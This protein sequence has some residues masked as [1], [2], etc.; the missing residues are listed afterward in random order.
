MMLDFTWITNRVGLGGAIWDA[1]NMAELARLGITHIIDMQIEFD[2]TRLAQPFGIAVCWN[3]TDDDFKPKPAELFRRG[4]EFAERALDDPQAKLYVHCAAGIHRGPMMALA[5][6]GST[7]WELD[8]A[9]DAIETKRPVAE[10][11]EVYLNSVK[12]F[13][14]QASTF[15]S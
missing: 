9:L 8:A 3:P 7:G 15:K 5:I 2:D 14:E 12:G 11:P 13:L 1:E 6:L 10:F 4:V